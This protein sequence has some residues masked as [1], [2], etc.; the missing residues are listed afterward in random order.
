[1][2]V[3]DVKLVSLSFASATGVPSL[4]TTARWV[5]WMA[6]R[7]GSIF[8]RQLFK[9]AQ[10]AMLDHMLAD[11]GIA[12]AAVI[13]VLLGCNAGGLSTYLHTDYIASVVPGAR[14]VARAA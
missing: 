13:V 7:R 9:R 1:M 10:E 4:V 12:A 6:C 14:T 2:N 11:R 8:P 5:W 3:N